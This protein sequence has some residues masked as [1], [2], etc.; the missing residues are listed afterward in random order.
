MT[1]AMEDREARSSGEICWRRPN[2]N[3]GR[4][5]I[6]RIRDGGRAREEALRERRC[7]TR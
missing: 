1:E 5:S 7:R 3:V 4:S 6:V 2:V